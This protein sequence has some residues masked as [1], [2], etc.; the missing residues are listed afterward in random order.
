MVKPNTIKGVEPLLLIVRQELEDE[1][2]KEPVPKV[3]FPIKMMLGERPYE[4]DQAI[5]DTSLEYDEFE[6][7]CDKHVE[8]FNKLMRPRRTTHLSYVLLK[9]LNNPYTF[10]KRGALSTSEDSAYG[11]LLKG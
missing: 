5:S 9:I 3:P 10:K 11:N 4:G 2:R 1:I 6:L 8:V 7:S